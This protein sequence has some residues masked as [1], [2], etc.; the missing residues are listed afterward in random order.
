MN[1]LVP[2]SVPIRKPSPESKVVGWSGAQGADWAKRNPKSVRDLDASYLERFGIT[3]TAVNEQMLARVP[4][5]ARVLEIGCAAG[6]Q[7]NALH[8][9]GFRDLHGCDLSSDALASCPWPHEVADGCD[10]PYEDETFDLVMTSGTFMHIPMAR[11]PAFLQEIMRVSRRWYYGV[12]MWS[13]Q[14]TMWD[15]AD[16]IPPAWTID[17]YPM[18]DSHGWPIVERL[19]LE[20]LNP[21]TGGRPLA[22]FLMERAG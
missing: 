18:L 1:F 13:H 17:W 8:A 16:L 19:H 12:E 4:R 9:I 21:E 3:R 7:L 5:D 22:C 11:K 15:F 20:A 6:A 2:T 14:P 10:L